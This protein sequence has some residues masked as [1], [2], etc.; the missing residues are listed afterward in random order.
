MLLL[1]RYLKTEGACCCE[2]D[3]LR[4]AGGTLAAGLHA[5]GLVDGGGGGG[6][7]VVE[8]CSRGCWVFVEAGAPE[9]ELAVAES[10]VLVATGAIAASLSRRREPGRYGLGGSVW[11]WPMATPAGRLSWKRQLVE[12]SQVAMICCS[13]CSGNTRRTTSSRRAT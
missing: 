3:K 8:E 10:R 12:V 5:V 9:D 7:E 1:P 2:G 6:R 11:R 4:G 13:P